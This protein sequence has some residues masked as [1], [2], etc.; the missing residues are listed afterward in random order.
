MRT[1]LPLLMLAAL[2]A[3]QP[4]SAPRGAD[5]LLAANGFVARPTGYDQLH[6]LYTSIR[7]HNQPMLVT[8]DCALHSFHV[9]Y[10]YIL[11]EAETRYFCDRLRELTQSLLAYEESVAVDVQN[12]A[13]KEA[14]RRNIAYLAVGAALLD[15][16]HTA[17]NAVSNMVKAELKLIAA[18]TGIDS[19]PVMGFAEDYSQY[20][21]RGHYTRSPKLERYFRAM[22]WYGRIGF[23]LKPGNTEPAIALGRRLTRQALLLC[24]ALRFNCVGETSAEAAWAGIYYPTAYLVGASDDLSA[25]DYLP[26]S[27]D[28]FGNLDPLNTLGDDARL[29]EFIRRAMQLRA[30][31]IV[32]QPVTDTLNPEDVTRGFRLMGQRFIPDA[33]MFQQL[34]YDKVGTQQVPRAMPKGL[35][36]MAVLGSDRARELLTAV[37]HADRYENYVTQLESLRVQFGRLTPA[38]WNRNAYYGWLYALK[39]M[40]EPV[41]RNK[42]LPK[43]CFQ[44]AYADKCLVTACGSWAQLRHDT[45]LYAKQSYTLMTTAMPTREP[46][47]ESMKVYVEPK[48]AVYA[49]VESLCT[50]MAAELTTF[51]VLSDEMADR[52]DKLRLLAGIMGDLARAEVAGTKLDLGSINHVWHIGDIMEDFATFPADSAGAP[53]NDEDRNMATVADVHTDPNTKTVLEEGVGQPLE[54]QAV[55]NIRGRGY[56][57]TG[58][59]LSYY[60][61]T[62]PMAD[63][64]T[65]KAWQ[66]LEKRPPMP[67]WTRSFAKE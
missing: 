60:E 63:R 56:T 37:Y 29:D 8:A 54:I 50:R 6:Q 2:L 4:A 15:S 65:D 32:S 26:L 11:R 22:M 10:D 33:Y 9:L 61:F 21:P 36:V 67:E 52:L 48:P 12:A 46:E 53:T 43:F 24:D 58:G 27:R 18:H 34:V 57:A 35:D 40:N 17:P 39:L 49:Q 38:D 20:V 62:W 44:V 51:G 16:T 55:V 28:V 19:S 41:T 47:P 3:A 42:L 45:I 59:M 30:P 64:M 14:L 5:E 25:S 66:E 31:G 1:I 13:V 7:K 23:A